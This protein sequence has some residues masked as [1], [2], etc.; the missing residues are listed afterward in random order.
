MLVLASLIG[1]NI[2]I[3]VGVAMMMLIGN[4]FA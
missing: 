2:L 4:L 3:G 1:A